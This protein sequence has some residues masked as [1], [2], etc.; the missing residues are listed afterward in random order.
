M[1]EGPARGK[2]AGSQERGAAEIAAWAGQRTGIAVRERGQREWMTGV[3][4]TESE[5]R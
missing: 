1:R 3:T 2:Q 5:E 4:R